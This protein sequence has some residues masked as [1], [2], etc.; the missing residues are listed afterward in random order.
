MVENSLLTSIYQ[1]QIEI[2]NLIQSDDFAQVTAYFVREDETIES[3]IYN[4]D[5]SYKNTNL[6]FLKNNS[7][8]VFVVAK[9]NGSSLILNSFELRLNEESKEQF[10]ILETSDNSPTGYKA[11]M[12]TQISE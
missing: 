10:L 3:T 7:Y 4:Q 11:T 6:I 9:D 1:H 8:Q 5:L 12:F 2:V